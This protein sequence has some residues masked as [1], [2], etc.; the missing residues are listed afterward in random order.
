MRGGYLG[1]GLRHFGLVRP[2]FLSRPGL[3]LVVLARPGVAGLA[4]LLAGHHSCGY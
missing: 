4:G 1:R 2:G 3:A